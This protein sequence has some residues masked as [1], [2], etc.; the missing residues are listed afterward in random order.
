MEDQSLHT[1][2]HAAAEHQPR[3]VHRHEA[4]K[5]V[6]G[7]G[8]AAEFNR[9]LA[10]W[11]TKNVGTMWCAY[12][13]TVVGVTGI[14]AALTNNTTI[15]LLVG[16]ISGY[17]LQLVLL[18]IIIVGQNVQAEATDRRAME[19]HKTLVA[20]HTMN[21]TQL[22]ILEALQKLTTQQDAALAKIAAK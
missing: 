3:M 1:D 5:A 18:P 6:H 2:V 15:V 21:K 9:T 12:V 13:F 11:V 7:E 16:A 20:L 17:F 10:V 4:S 14:V 22:E 19:D 8:P